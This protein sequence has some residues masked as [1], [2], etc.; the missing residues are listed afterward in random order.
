MYKS[1]II[2]FRKGGYLASNE[3]WFYDEMKMEVVNSYMYFGISFTTQLSFTFACEELACRGKKAVIDILSK[4]CKLGNFSFDVFF[5]IFDAQVQPI[6]LYGAEIW[7]VDNSSYVIEKLHISAMKK[8]VGVGMQT[9]NDLINVELGRF[10]ISIN[11]QIR[12][13]RY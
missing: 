7:G 11:A 5:K 13:V 1:N 8:M 9:P 3:R 4:L 12:C 6:V 10:P 2:V